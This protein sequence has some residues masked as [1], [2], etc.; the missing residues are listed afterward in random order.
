MKY[1]RLFYDLLTKHSSLLRPPYLLPPLVLRPLAVLNF[2]G[3]LRT[4]SVCELSLTPSN[5]TGINHT[6][7]LT[8]LNL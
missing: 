1:F 7:T 5:K 4:C 3:I 6:L 2:A 8:V